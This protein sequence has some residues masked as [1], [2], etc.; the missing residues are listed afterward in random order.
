VPDQALGKYYFFLVLAASF[1][2][3]HSYNTLINMFKFGTFLVH[4]A[5][6]FTLLRFVEF[7]RK[8]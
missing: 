4:F 7:F 8:M 6:F 5:I 2:V 3:K 1:F